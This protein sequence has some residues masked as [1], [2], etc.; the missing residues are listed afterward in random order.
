M[1]QDVS[2]AALVAEKL[3]A[4][5][6][7]QPEFEESFQYLQDMQGQQR[8]AEVPVASTVRY[9]H[10]LWVCERKDYLLSV[11]RTMGRYEGRRALEVLRDWQAGETAGSSISCAASWMRCPLATLRASWKRPGGRRAR[12]HWPSAWRMVGWSCCIAA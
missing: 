2:L 12:V 10:A 5:E 3:A 7:L 6:R 4:F 1:A 11:P 8:F 9:L